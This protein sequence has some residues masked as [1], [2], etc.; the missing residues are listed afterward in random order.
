MRRIVEIYVIETGGKKLFIRLSSQ[1]KQEN[2]L[3][4]LL[5]DNETERQHQQQRENKT[6]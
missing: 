5:L 2:Y 6:E 1:Q 4:L 3:R